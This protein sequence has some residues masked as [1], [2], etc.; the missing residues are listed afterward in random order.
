[1][2]KFQRPPVA[3][4]EKEKQRIADEF[5]E[6]AARSSSVDKPKKDGKKA[7]LFLRIP[8]NLEDD[9]QRIERL[10]GF[11]KNTFCLLA[12][13]EAVKDKLKQIER[14]ST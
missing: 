5:I 2:T 10:T 4:S 11:K 7:A 6:G 3:L 14:E 8:Q 13:L 9:L 12:I 1:M